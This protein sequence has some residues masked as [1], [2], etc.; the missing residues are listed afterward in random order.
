MLTC[1][2]VQLRQVTP[3]LRVAGVVYHHLPGS[4]MTKDVPSDLTRMYDLGPHLYRV[5]GRRISPDEL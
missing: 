5:L 4:H 3:S 2:Y 1:A